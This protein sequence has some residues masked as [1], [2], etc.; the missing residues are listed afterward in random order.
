MS[1]R[2][3]ISNASFIRYLVAGF[4]TVAVDVG[5]LFALVH[6]AH[7]NV[8]LAATISFWT[9]LVVN[10]GLNKL[11]TFGV[12]QNTPHHLTF[13]GAIILLN[14]LVGLLFIA[15]ARELHL[16]Y[17]VGKLAALAITTGWNYFLYKH[18][19]FVERDQAWLNLDKG[20]RNKQP[21]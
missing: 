14:Y 10:F 18:V 9:S 17:L 2:T 12:K 20:F 8:Y 7:L 19:V 15:F 6:I 16:S 3:L 21:V 1:V 13:Y 11:W 5:M 4:A